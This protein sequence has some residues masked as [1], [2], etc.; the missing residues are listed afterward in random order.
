MGKGAASFQCRAHT[1]TNP[2]PAATQNTVAFGCCA[3]F[4]FSAAQRTWINK[5]MLLKKQPHGACSPMARNNFLAGTPRV[6]LQTKLSACI[7]ELHVGL[8][9]KLRYT[10]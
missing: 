5:G 9:L 8:N 6:V 4:F 10:T 1:Y 7:A 2:L 3:R